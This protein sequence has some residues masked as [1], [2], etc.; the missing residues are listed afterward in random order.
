MSSILIQQKTQNYNILLIYYYGKLMSHRMSEFSTLVLRSL[1]TDYINMDL[2]WLNLLNIIKHF[3]LFQNRC[4]GLSPIYFQENN[5][6]I[7]NLTAWDQASPEISHI[8][9][10]CGFCLFCLQKCKYLHC[11]RKHSQTS[12]INKIWGKTY[13]EPLILL[14]R[15]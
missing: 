13:I 8:C 2:V 1:S 10:L 4:V 14:H 15:C 5:V 9:T 11:K 12:L 6:P 3:I 7:Y